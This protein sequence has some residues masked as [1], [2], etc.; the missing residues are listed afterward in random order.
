MKPRRL[1]LALHGYIGIITGILLVVISLTGSLLVFSHEIDHFLHPH[2]LQVAPQGNQVSPQ[3]V[4]QIAQASQPNLK[5]HRITMPRSLDEAYTVMM[6]SPQDEYTDVYINPYSGAVLGSRPWKQEIGGWLIDFHVHLFAGDRGMNLVGVCGGIFLVMSF[7]GLLLWKGWQRL[8]YGFTIRWQAPRQLLNYDLH[9]AIGVISVALLSLIATTGMAMVFWTPFEAAVYELTRSPKPPEFT[10]K[11]IANSSPMGINE[12]LQKAQ[13]ALPDARVFKFF[14]AK[15][16]DATFNVW[17]EV[18][19]EHEFNKNPYLR[20]DQYTGEI[21]HLSGWKNDSFS[22][23]LLSAPYILHVGNYGGILTRILYF[24]IGLA[25]L[26]LLI[27]GFSLWQRRRW[28]AAHRKEGIQ[29]S[30]RLT[31]KL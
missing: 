7:T 6:A 15:T 3:Q 8:R 21:L 25:P 24:L 9:K 28:L 20:L 18:A 5:P 26:G 11:I 14:P 1:A 22:D 30:Q 10:S 19:H 29:H 16:P 13:V 4:V 23:R 2:L 27:T 12:L 17:L 31:E